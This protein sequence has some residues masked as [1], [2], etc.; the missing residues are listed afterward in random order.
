MKP[1]IGRR[2]MLKSAMTALAAGPG[3]FD[4][5]ITDSEV[6]GDIVTETEGGLPTIA[7]VTEN[8]SFYVYQCCGTPVIT[9]P[10]TC[11]IVDR[12]AVVA[13]LDETWFEGR[14]P[15]L[16]EDTLQC[17]GSTPYSQ[18]IGN[19]VWGGMALTDV[20]AE[21]GV[22]VSPSIVEVGLTGHDG[23]IASVPVGDLQ[24]PLWMVWQMNGVPLPT[25]HGFPARI[26][27]PSR[28]GV[29]NVKWV[30]RIELSDTIVAN[31]WDP[32]G[33]NHEAPVRVNGFILVP[34]TGGTV[35]EAP[36]LLGTAF[37]GTDPVV[38]VEVTVNGGAWTDAAIDY[39]PGPHIWTLWHFDLN[40]S[41]GEHTAQ[42]R[43]TSESGVMSNLNPE[44]SNYLDGYD[45]GQFISFSIA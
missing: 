43:V 18:L 22:T 45:G 11:E 3:C 35:N 12:G 9:P 8:G 7:A 29:K 4:V 5:V 38:R 30:Q 32:A 13:T 20:L 19:A 31:F 41:T 14:E 17:I 21:L 1:A 25:E 28:Y 24:R 26:I 37:G 42:V 15:V 44:G 39:A 23:Y 10:W 16:V 36:R 40:L 6:N 27:A 2:E 33:W 34:Q